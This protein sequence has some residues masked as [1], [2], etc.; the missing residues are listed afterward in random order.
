MSKSRITGDIFGEFDKA[1][2][3]KLASKMS[4]M[5]EALKAETPVDTGHARD[6]WHVRG[7]SIVNEVDYIDELNRGT[8]EQAPSHFIESTL[9]SQEGVRPSGTI[10]RPK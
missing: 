6:G 2:Q 10:V 1:A 7:N 3:A 8:S 9:L 5:V 4:S